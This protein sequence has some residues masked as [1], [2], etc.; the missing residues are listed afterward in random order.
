MMMV[1]PMATDHYHGPASPMAMVMMVVVVL[2]E[3]NIG[4]RGGWRALIHDFQGRGG[5][6]DGLQ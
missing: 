6:R 5:I 4:V 2:S 1:V 3:L